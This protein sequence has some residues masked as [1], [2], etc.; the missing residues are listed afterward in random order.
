M[1][2]RPAASDAHSLSAYVSCPQSSRGSLRPCLENPGV[3]GKAP[4]SAGHQTRQIVEQSGG[5]YDPS[6]TKLRSKPGTQEA[7][8]TA[9]FGMPKAQT[10]MAGGKYR[11][12][13]YDVNLVKRH[14]VNS[15]INNSAKT[16]LEQ[17][18]GITTK[19]DPAM[20]ARKFGANT[21]DVSLVKRHDDNSAINND[22]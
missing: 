21:Y 17:S 4:V 22:Q 1:Q 2:P 10:G 3:W 8:V 11:P 13:T 5:N 20:K 18:G 19:A 7:V 9:A 12:N 14:D 16:A 6:G 15:A